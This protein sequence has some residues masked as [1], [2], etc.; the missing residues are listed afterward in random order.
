MKTSI[1]A[2]DFSNIST[3]AEIWSISM[4]FGALALQAQ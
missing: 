3:C 1:P 2:E 4:L